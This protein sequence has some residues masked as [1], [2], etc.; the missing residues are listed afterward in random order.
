V[1]PEFVARLRQSIGP[2]ELLWLPGV[3]AVVFDDAGRV[4]L[5]QSTGHRRWSILCG[6]LDP[7]EKPADGVRR[8]IWEETSVIATVDRLVGIT[9]S[10]V[11]EHVN[12]DRAQYLELTFR[13][14]AV[15]GV[16]RV[17][18]DESEA[19]AWFAI[20]ELPAMEPLTH[21][22]IALAA[23]NNPEPWFE[24]SAWMPALR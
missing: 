10:P 18:D 19:I 9:V 11:R 22:K 13:C 21:Q 5:Q 6:I 17:N 14:S 1:I 3:N 8:E 7:G 12:G 16:A 4:L 24:P 20:D 15:D 2:H 23:Q